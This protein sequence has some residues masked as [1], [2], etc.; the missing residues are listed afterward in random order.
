MDPIELLAQV[1]AYSV[2]AALVILA[3]LG[4]F[5]QQ[6]KQ[7]YRRQTGELRLHA[8]TKILPLRLAAYERAVLYLERINP[9]NSL[10]RHTRLQP[11]LGGRA[12]CEQLLNEL[13]QEYE[14][15][16]VQQLYISEAGWTLLARARLDVSRLYQDV[17]ARLPEQATGPDFAQAVYDR[18]RAW[19]ENSLLQ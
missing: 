3:G 15:N 6:L 12:L 4:I 5:R 17:Q 9:V 16:Q 7:E 1:L 14:H 8:Y 13:E 18:M 10:V 19:E 11:Q 2:P